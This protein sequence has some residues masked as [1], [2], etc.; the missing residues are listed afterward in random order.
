VST[1]NP[2]REHPSTYFV[3]DRSN[4]Q[5]LERVR[6][7]DEMLTHMMGGVLPEQPDPTL[8]REVLDVGCG[9]GGWLI[10]AAKSYP[11]MKRLAGV[12]VSGKMIEYARERAQAE[13]VADRVEFYVMDALRLL[14]FPDDSFDLINQRLGGSYLRTWDWPNLLQKYQRVIRA[15]GT[16]RITESDVF[17]SNTPAF[18]QLSDIFLTTLFKAG[19]FKTQQMD[20]LMHTL[21]PLLEQQGFQQVQTRPHLMRYPAGTY[22]GK[23]FAEDAKHAFRTLAPFFRKWTRLP[24]NYEELYQQT[25]IEMKQPDFVGAWNMLTVW[26]HPPVAKVRSQIRYQ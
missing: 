1:E 8:F 3:Q 15:H 17:H 23:L 19:H 21:A 7:Q 4:L 26:G 12:D 24:D 16:I 11:T 14:E 10:E 5:E 25:L 22:E 18:T 9:C 13:G 6:L 2:K 20:G